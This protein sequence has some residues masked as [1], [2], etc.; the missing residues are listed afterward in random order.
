MIDYIQQL[1]DEGL[2]NSSIN[3]TVKAL[4]KL[5]RASVDRGL[6]AENP[7]AGIEYLPEEKCTSKGKWLSEEQLTVLFDHLKG[8]IGT[9]TGIR[10][11]AIF[12]VLLMTGIR[13]NEL[14]NLRWNDIKFDAAGNP[15]E[16]HVRV[17][18]GGKQRTVELDNRVFGPLMEYYSV[19]YKTRSYDARNENIFWTVPCNR[20]P[21]R[22]ILNRV[23][24]YYIV[25][26]TGERLG[27]RLHPHNL[28]HT[29][30]THS[31]K[32]GASLVAVKNRLGHSSITTTESIYIHDE[33]KCLEYLNFNFI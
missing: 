15:S 31:L 30:A 19:I 20:Y 17:A 32:R 28:R 16:L 10:D 14:C 3:T 26:R 7:A 29:Y 33:D 5:F 21:E 23:A 4:K 9:E 12:T 2:K 11:Y 13:A 22:R 1:R 8:R 6:T 24:L 25:R 18:K 27:T